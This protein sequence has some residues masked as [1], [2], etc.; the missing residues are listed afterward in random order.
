MIM[1]MKLGWY[2]LTNMDFQKKNKKS[3][4]EV[5]NR[6]NICR[7]KD[8]SQSPDVWI[9]ELYTLNFNFNKIKIKYEKDE[10]EMES[11]VFDLLPE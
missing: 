4:N 11:H 7:V 6:W 2:S 5:A 3:L 8:T 9:N 1:N 10:N